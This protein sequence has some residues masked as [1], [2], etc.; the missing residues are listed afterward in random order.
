MAFGIDL[1]IVLLCSVCAAHLSYAWVP[2]DV[3][4]GGYSFSGLSKMEVEQR[5]FDGSYP[6]SQFRPASSTSG[7]GQGNLIREGTGSNT[8]SQRPLSRS[9]ASNGHKF[10]SG[11]YLTS[12]RTKGKRVR[13]NISDFR[14]SD[15]IASGSSFSQ[16][17]NTQDV[18]KLDQSLSNPSKKIVSSSE[19]KR[20]HPIPAVKVQ[21]ALPH[22]SKSGAMQSSYI[23]SRLFNNKQR[24]VAQNGGFNSR[25]SNLK[26]NHYGQSSVN[27]PDFPSR[28]ASNF[29]PST[30]VARLKF[31]STFASSGPINF[32]EKFNLIGKIPSSGPSQMLKPAPL[33]IAAKS[34]KPIF[35]PI[36]KPYQS[37][38]VSSGRALGSNP[39]GQT[40][41]AVKYPTGFKAAIGQLM[42]PKKPSYT[43]WSVGSRSDRG[44]NQSPS[45]NYG[46][47]PILLR[48][49]VVATYNIPEAYGGS[50]IRRLKQS[51]QQSG[52]SAISDL[53]LLTASHR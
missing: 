18:R 26:I 37:I 33:S 36:V 24:S 42:Q 44:P 35:S 53:R 27:V 9:P 34:F 20:V 6:Q 52:A 39:F 29:K 12:A 1:G 32:S 7:S 22:S 45:A 50:P 2:Y 15:S 46:A 10:S 48:S 41:S 11:N 23:E 47:S 19:P 8:Y 14:L 51:T 31:G 28:P 3:Q 25:D 21:S 13:F 40:S 43:Q 16:K 4:K 17:R 30:A 5:K 49:D 38:Y